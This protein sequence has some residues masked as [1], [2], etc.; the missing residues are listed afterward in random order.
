[1]RGTVLHTPGHTPGSLSLHLAG[2]ALIAGD[3]LMGGH[4][5][6]MVQPTRPRYHY[7]AANID[8]VRASLARVLGLRPTRMYVGHGGPLAPAAITQALGL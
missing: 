2:G 6:G 1:V 7:I 8:Q 4:L 5:G 3:L